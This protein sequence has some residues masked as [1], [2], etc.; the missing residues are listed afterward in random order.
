MNLS[1]S[2]S[3]HPGVF[4]NLFVAL[5]KAG[6]VSGNLNEILDQLASYLENLDD[7]RRKVKSAMNYPIFMV[8]FLGVMLSAMFLWIIPKFSDVYA[9]LGAN[10]PSATKQLMNFSAWF[11]Q[12]AGFMTFTIIVFMFVLWLLSKTQRGG[13]I[14]D[15]IKLKIPVFGSLINQSIL[16][17]FCK[18]FGIL[19]GAGV[20]VLES[21]ALLKKVV[22]NKVYAKAIHD[23]SDY[24]RDGYNISTALRRTEVFPS[25]LLQLASTGE[26]TGELDDLLDRAANYYQKQVDALVERMTTLIEPLL[27]LLVGAVIALMVVLT[28][29]PV[30][31]LGSALQS[32]L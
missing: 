15:S 5:T 2:L 26:D 22:E 31:H 23:A 20:P 18:T 10:L 19:L 13:F 6:E 12:N 21:T 16:N 25:I 30:F 8:I 7:T 9:Q 29:L 1:E 11:S 3:R 27:I 32:G 24:I 17:K 14:L 4:N 28:Y